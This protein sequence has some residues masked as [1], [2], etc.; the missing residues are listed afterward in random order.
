M[1]Q[2]CLPSQEMLVL[3]E[4]LDGQLW[5]GDF[6]GGSIIWQRSEDFENGQTLQLV[7]GV[8]AAELG[9]TRSDS[10]SSGSNLGVKGGGTRKTCTIC[11]EDYRCVNS[12]TCS[13]LFMLLTVQCH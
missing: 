4:S 5:L 10:D 1:L 13:C 9:T 7:E 8:H 6:Q 3:Y 11:I 2:A 12:L